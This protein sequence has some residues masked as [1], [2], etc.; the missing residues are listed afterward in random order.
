MDHALRLARRGLGNVWPN[1]AVGCVI[2]REGRI[3]GRGW[4]QPGGRP[5]AERMALDHAGSLAQGATAYVTLEP[6]AHHG[7]TPP[8]A[9]GLI[10]AGIRRV[11]SAMTD[12]DPRVAGRG[13]AMLEDAGISVAQGVRQAEAQE[14]QAGFLSRILAG[15]P[16]VTLKLATSFDGRIAT[17]SGESKWITGPQ[18]RLHVHAM[19]MAHDAVMVGGNTARADRPSLNVRG[20]TTPRQPLRVVL[21]SQSLPDLPPE[22]PMHGP[23][24]QID[25]SAPDALRRLAQQGVTRVF[26]EGGG[27]LAA[28]LLQA[29]L[30]DQ[31]IGYTAGV[32]LGGEG[33][34]GI[35]PMGLVHL[36]DAPQFQLMETRP[37]GGDLFHRWRRITG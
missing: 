19:R 33:R 28:S 24:L 32:V 25:A 37:L 34:A 20:L 27:V 36:A 29:G 7:R 23:L 21:S 2:L 1:P 3:V 16:F 14:L 22:G 31:V 26:C 15:R 10:A 12:P 17:A 35:G 9:E 18:A 5:H 4:T 13:H 8:C 6:C 11:V 30:V